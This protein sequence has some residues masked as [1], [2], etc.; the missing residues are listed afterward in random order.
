MSSM[1]VVVAIASLS[2]APLVAAAQAATTPIATAVTT[3]DGAPKVMA[4]WVEQEAN[5]AYMGL[6]SY[7]SCDGIG[8][9]VRRI[10]KSIGVRPGFKVSVRSCLDDAVVNGSLGGVARM[11]R[12]YITASLP[13]PATPELLAELSKPDAKQELIAR[14]KGTGDAIMEA[15]AQF[16]AQW[17]RVEILANP[18]GPV[19]LGD[20]ELVDEMAEEVFAQLGA[21]IID[22]QIACVPRQLT[23]GSVRLTLEV[24]QPVLEK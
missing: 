2:L 5:F 6:T 20:C 7:Y 15:T 23:L 22:D 18:I 8:D 14:V 17:R 12:V 21:R 19:Q 13:Q 16:P 9:K 24:L 1:R 3:A 10:L 4:V 11:P